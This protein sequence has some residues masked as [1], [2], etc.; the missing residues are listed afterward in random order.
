[1]KKDK[2]PCKCLMIGI[3]CVFPIRLSRKK[4]IDIMKNYISSILVAIVVITLSVLGFVFNPIALTDRQLQ[5]LIV[6]LIICGSAAL[7]CFVVGEISRNNSQMDKLWSLL[8]IAYTW[9]I[10]GMG[11]WNPRLVIIAVLVTLWGIRL[12]ANFARKGAYS[13]KFWD[14][15]EDYRWKILR[16]KKPFNNKLVWACFNLFFISIYQ[17]ALVLAI[18]LPALM[19]I[20][21]AAPLGTFDYLGAGL[22]AFFL[23]YETIADEQQMAYHTTKRLLLNEGK[24]LEE[25]PYPF[26]LGFNVT[27][28]WRFSRHPNYLG[29]QAFWLCLY[30]FVI[31]SGNVTYNFFSWTLVGPLFLIFLFLGSSTLGEKISGGKYPEYQNYTS[32]VFKYLPVRRYNPNKK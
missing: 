3:I 2:R 10:A 7:Y 29:E 25:L 23:L 27:G 1:M 8:P 19:C 18:C 17:N 13:I 32:Q 26:C 15:E 12:T 20:D 6:L 21:S 4:E 22:S 9:V 14:G 24:K 28:L 16:E 5:T 31:G 11:N 30:L